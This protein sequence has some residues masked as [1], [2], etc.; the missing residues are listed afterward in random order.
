MEKWF[1]SRYLQDPLQI[2]DE[3]IFVKVPVS[4]GF[5]MLSLAWNGA[6]EWLL[7]RY[8]GSS[9][10]SKLSS[11]IFAPRCICCRCKAFEAHFIVRFKYILILKLLGMLW[12][13][14]KCDATLQA[15]VLVPKKYHWAHF[16][17]NCQTSKQ[18]RLCPT[19]FDLPSLT[20]FL[21]LQ[22]LASACG[23][24]WIQ[25]EKIQQVCGSLL[26]F[27][28]CTKVCPWP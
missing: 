12:I 24:P 18:K 26:S 2:F 16:R 17:R 11:S 6:E 19:I 25:W 14:S 21:S 3:N 20:V 8:P 28:Y 5:H 13:I 4:W 15:H 1:A 22:H 27:C 10:S 23:T 7:W 9:H